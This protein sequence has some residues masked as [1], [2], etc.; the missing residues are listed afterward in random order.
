MHRPLV[1]AADHYLRDEALLVLGRAGLTAV[2]C[3]DSAAFLR[4]AGPGGAGVVLLPYLARNGWL[5]WLC[6]LGDEHPA[7]QVVLVT[8]GEAENLRSLGRVKVRQVLFESELWQLPASLPADPIE[9]VLTELDAAISDA[10]DLPL[11]LRRTL[12]LGLRLTRGV[13]GP[14]SEAPVHT[15]EEL[16]R[17]LKYS[18]RYIRRLGSQCRVPIGLLIDWYLALHAIRLILFQGNTV[19]RA[20][21][22]LGFGRRSGL[23]ALCARVSGYRPSELTANDVTRVLTKFEA[24]I[25]SSLRNHG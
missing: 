16:A 25:L 19:E 24:E 10:Q 18:P 7:F 14:D 21:W 8:K 1:L 3:E 23:S 20:A 5:D 15:V 17:R 11:A 9:S 4:R 22:R 12:R 6:V 13:I 2:V